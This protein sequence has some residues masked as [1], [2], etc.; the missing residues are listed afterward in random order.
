MCIY[1]EFTV[2][3][4]AVRIV[5]LGVYVISPFLIRIP[6]NYIPPVIQAGYRGTALASCCSRID[7]EFTARN[8][9]NLKLAEVGDL[10][11]ITNTEALAISVE[12]A[13]AE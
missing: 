4:V 6:C 2:H 8:P 11:V 9:E 12:A 10:V 7:Q 13:P 5:S 1:T 3:F